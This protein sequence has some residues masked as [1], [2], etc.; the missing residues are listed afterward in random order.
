MY[1]RQLIDSFPSAWDGIEVIVFG[2]RFI[3]G[4]LQP[5]CWNLQ[6]LSLVSSV[7]SFILVLVFL[8][9]FIFLLHFRFSL[10]SEYREEDAF[11]AGLAWE[12]TIDRDV[13]ADAVSYTHLARRPDG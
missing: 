9:F 3:V 13:C 10:F 6:T 12:K 1:K 7:L 4:R 11:S 2:Y 8:L 5:V